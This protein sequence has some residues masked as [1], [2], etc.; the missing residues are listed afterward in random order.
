MKKILSIMLAVML[1]FTLTA[2]NTG[3][4][5]DI[6]I[7]EVEEKEPFVPKVAFVYSG[8]I[9]NSAHNNIWETSRRALEKNLDIDTYYMENVFVQNFHEAVEILAKDDFNVIVSTSHVFANGVER[10]SQEYKDVNFISL[11]GEKT[12]GNVTIFNPLLY[13]PAYIAGLAASVNTE[14]DSIGI[15]ADDVMF[16]AEGVINA[17]I[18]GAKMTFSNLETYLNWAAS[19]S[20]E[21]IRAAI[22]DLVEKGHD[23]IM[24]YLNSDYGIKYA[25]EIGVKV[26]AYSN[27]LPEIAPRNYVTGFFY[28]VNSYVTEQVRFMQN[29]DFIPNRVYGSMATGHSSLIGFNADEDV[30]D[31]ITRTLT[32]GLIA[33]IVGNSNDGVFVGSIVDHFGRTQ[34]EHGASLDYKEALKIKWLEYSTIARIGIFTKAVEDP[35]ISP[36]EIRQ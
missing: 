21:E 22:D 26:I 8:T 16:N 33:N 23:L 19:E 25:E 34:V 36:L 30:V 15:V 3:E 17:Y 7:P 2:C 29:D 20:E 5:L 1:I 24:L 6:P 4:G 28:N 27:N 12:L 35:P 18:E 14:S 32:D 31:P 10:A 13:Q 9:D 11:G